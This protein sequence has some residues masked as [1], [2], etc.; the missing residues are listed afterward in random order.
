MIVADIVM[1]MA[2]YDCDCYMGD[3]DVD[4]SAASKCRCCYCYYGLI[5][6]FIHQTPLCK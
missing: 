6:Y 2:C 1:M 5:D 3:G 4:D